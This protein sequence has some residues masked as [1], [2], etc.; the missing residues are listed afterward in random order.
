MSLLKLY[1]QDA[2]SANIISATPVLDKLKK[3][4]VK[5][6]LE[7]TPKNVLELNYFTFA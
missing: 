4:I 1:I 7:S 5:V 3:R 2:D 6:S